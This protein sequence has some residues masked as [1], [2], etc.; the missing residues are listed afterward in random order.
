ML[1][2]TLSFLAG[3]VLATGLFAQA[4]KIEFPAASPA[5]TVKQ[6]VGV[7]DIEVNYSRPS[8]RGRKIFG[9]LLPY[10][11]IWRT[12][13]NNATK[14]TFSTAVKFGGVDVPAGSYALFS[15][16]GETEWTVILNKV[17]D[18]W[19]WGA[20]SYDAKNDL[21]RVKAV[22]QRLPVPVETFTISFSDLSKESAAALM[23][24]WENVR[25]PVA[26]EVD[27]AST[28]VPQIE[29]AM[30]ATEGKKPYFAS[31]MFYYENGLDLKKAA[32]WMDAAIAE[33]PDAFYMIYRKGLILEK[34][35][36]KTGALAAAQKSLEMSRKAPGLVGTEYTRLNEA[37]IARLK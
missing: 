2:V 19:P 13:A 18:K 27:V 20:Y 14:I 15:I 22:P 25:V 3:S 5:A 1:R 33:Q 29:A 24:Y 4:P 17:P 34:A 9:G 10:G 7:T 37:L 36:D 31:A 6:R 8:M 28:L 16:P 23:L 11:E 30:A 12:G 32:A 35:G 21:V 26:I